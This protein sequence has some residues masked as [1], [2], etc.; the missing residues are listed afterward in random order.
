[1]TRAAESAMA[2]CRRQLPVLRIRRPVALESRRVGRR[3]FSCHTL[4]IFL[5]RLLLRVRGDL[6]N[7]PAPCARNDNGRSHVCIGSVGYTPLKQAA[8]D[9]ETLLYVQSSPRRRRRDTRDT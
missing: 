5:S 8:M 1:M 9:A 3:T 4:G 2:A 6:G 7:N